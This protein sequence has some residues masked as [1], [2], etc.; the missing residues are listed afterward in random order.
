MPGVTSIR[1]GP[2]SSQVDVAPRRSS[3]RADGGSALVIDET[4]RLQ[5][6]MLNRMPVIDPY[7]IEV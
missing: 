3:P 1:R 4:A 6:S 5:L 7:T 2:K